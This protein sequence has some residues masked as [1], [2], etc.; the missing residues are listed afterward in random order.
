M[1]V[2][3]VIGTL[4]KCDAAPSLPA[5]RLTTSSHRGRRRLHWSSLHW[6]FPETCEN[7]RKGTTVESLLLDLV[8]LLARLL[9]ALVQVA[10]DDNAAI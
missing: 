10:E 3:G 1:G 6:R 7:Y 9:L 8:N 5:R 2:V 4:S